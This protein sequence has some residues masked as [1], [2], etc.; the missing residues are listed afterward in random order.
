MVALGLREA[1]L[2]IFSFFDLQKLIS[3]WSA[4]CKDP[5]F[6]SVRAE[7]KAIGLHREDVVG[8]VAVTLL[9]IVAELPSLLLAPNNIA[10]AI[11]LSNAV[12][13]L[14]VFATGYSWGIHTGSNP[15]KT[16]LLLASVCLAMVLVAIVV[17]G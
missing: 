9:A 1:Q 13:F 8:A 15:W 17:G 14:V 7:P 5:K 11:R 3:Y 2:I 4:V 6:E 16:G 10:L 12:S